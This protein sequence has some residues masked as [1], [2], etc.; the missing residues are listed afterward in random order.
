MKDIRIYILGFSWPIALAAG[1]LLLIND[2]SA[3]N[4][5]VRLV[6]FDVTDASGK[7]IV[8]V[9]VE[10]T[11]ETTRQSYRALTKEF[12]GGHIDL[13]YGPYVASF[14]KRHFTPV[15]QTLIVEF[16]HF[17]EYTLHVVMHRVVPPFF[18][19]VG[20]YAVG[21][22]ALL[23]YVFSVMYIWTLASYPYEMSGSN[24]FDLRG[25]FAGTFAGIAIGA[26]AAVVSVPLLDTTD[27]SWL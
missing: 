10:F 20:S 7:D 16:E 14:K 22:L 2:L 11:N 3:Q 12:L 27:G 24:L 19:R 25:L 8:G 4:V 17:P 15:T 13:P 18:V 5:P 9:E 6:S 23:F 26:I 21:G 1:T